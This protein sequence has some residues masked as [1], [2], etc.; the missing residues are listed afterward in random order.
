VSIHNFS[1][2]AALILAGLLNLKVNCPAREVHLHKS[3]EHN[4]EYRNLGR[5]GLKLS[6]V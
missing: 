6:A 1:G 5:S 3:K 2:S 4:V